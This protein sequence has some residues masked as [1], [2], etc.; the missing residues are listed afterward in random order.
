MK[1]RW[2]HEYPYSSLCIRMIRVFLI[3]RVK[4]MKKNI[5]HTHQC[6]NLDSS[7]VGEKVIV[8]GWIENIR[9]HGGVLFLDLRDNTDTIQGTFIS[10]GTI[11]IAHHLTLAGQLL[12]NK[13]VIDTDLDG[14][15]FIFKPFEVII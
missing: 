10:T 4:E 13:I 15:G 8:S 2:H 9:D 1:L 11:K 14:S 6:I 7:K 12:A 5:Y 3:E